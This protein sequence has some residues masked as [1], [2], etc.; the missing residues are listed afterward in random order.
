MSTIAKKLKEKKKA[1]KPELTPVTD[2]QHQEVVELLRGRT[3]EM[4]FTVHGIPKSRKIGGKL[5]E[6]VAASISGKKKGVRAS[7]SMFTSDHPAV[8]ELNVAIRELEQLRETWTIVRSAEVQK[9]EGDRV[10]IE[11]GKR[12][13]WDKDIP[14]FHA[15][16]TAKAKLIDKCV[17]K[18][19][20]AMDHVTYDADDNPI[21]SVKDMD[22]EN[23]GEAWDESV[24]PKDLTLVVG[25]SKERNGDGS[26]RLD[27]QGEP[28]YI[29]NFNEYHVS[30]K[31]PELLKERAVKRI[32]EGLSGTIET[33]MTYAA[34]ELSD[35]MMTF[36]G[37][38]TNRV[39]VYP[40]VSGQYGKMYEGEI[41]KQVT[42]E[43]D[44]KIPAGHVKALIRYKEDDDTKVTK[45]VGPVKKAAFAAEFK[46]QATGEKKKIYPS[47]I[48]SIIEQLTA[49]KDKKA[50][51][52]GAYGDNMVKAFE[53]LLDALLAAKKVN[54]YTSATK[55]AQQLAS[56]LK[57]DDEAKEAMSKA[58]TD[59]VEMLEEQV[60][61]VKATHQKRRT[62]KASLMGKV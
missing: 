10:T 26:P 34:N 47:V 27:D 49:F 24:Y 12:L 56:V 38:L 42:D 32:D 16:F 36:L 22:R 57:T 21:K 25:V 2:K 62:I 23:A 31:L 15:L 55:A 3:M 30:E 46:P 58:I 29:I 18:L 45:W 51:M 19:Q 9:G 17:G 48:E 43:T 41:I 37:E 8:K 61:T 7:W 54:P 53:P 40:A 39:K 11:G 5:G 33:A 44:P 28:I 4:S 59:T 13:I 20:H 52:L 14:E 35:Q 50:K 1:P 60:V 6:K